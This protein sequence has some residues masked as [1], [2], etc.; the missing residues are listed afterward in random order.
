M[1]AIPAGSLCR[2][3][4]RVS[5]GVGRTVR[6]QPVAEVVRLRLRPE[7]KSHDFRYTLTP[8]RAGRRL[9]SVGDVAQLGERL[10]GIQEVR[11]SN[12]LIS[13]QLTVEF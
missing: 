7:R 11:D 5:S 3:I 6:V 8:Y 10:N 2:R 1:P 4:R 9:P 12:P 13:T